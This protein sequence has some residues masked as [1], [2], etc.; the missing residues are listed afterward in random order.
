MPKLI[1]FVTLV[2][3]KSLCQ[4]QTSNAINLIDSS[5]NLYAKEN[6]SGVVLVAK[7]KQIYI[8]HLRCIAFLH[9]SYK[10]ER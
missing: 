1:F 10:R 2:L 5:M 9:Q 7:G 8:Y 4:G 6:F 3:I